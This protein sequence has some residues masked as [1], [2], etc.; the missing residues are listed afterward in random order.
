MPTMRDAYDEANAYNTQIQRQFL[1]PPAFD[2]PESDSLNLETPPHG[3]PVA[4]ARQSE[5]VQAELA[6]A[7]SPPHRRRRV[8]VPL[9]LFLLTC[10]STFL[11][12]ATGWMPGEHLWH[13][14][15]E[16]PEFQ[17]LTRL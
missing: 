1:L 7:P 15:R 13:G 16:G 17:L 2:V 3:A 14:F 10:A 6:D 9:V 12:G 4:K 11:A 8:L 5:M